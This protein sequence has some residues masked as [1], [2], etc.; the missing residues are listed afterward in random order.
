[1]W[2]LGWFVSANTWMIC[3]SPVESS[4]I[5]PPRVDPLPPLPLGYMCPTGG[6]RLSK[7][8]SS[9]LSFASSM[10]PCWVCLVFWDVLGS[11]SPICTRFRG[12]AVGVPRH[13]VR[14]K[15]IE[16]WRYIKPVSRRDRP[17][18]LFDNEKQRTQDKTNY[19]NSS[20]INSWCT[21]SGQI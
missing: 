5:S 17:E 11:R 4:S 16:H 8:F 19:N 18:A 2:G 21:V 3:F 14:S 15:V 13:E 9:S 6:L 12:I 10:T 1:M 7:D 20:V